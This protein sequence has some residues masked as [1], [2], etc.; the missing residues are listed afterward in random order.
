MRLTQLALKLSQKRLDLK[1]DPEIDG[2][3]IAMDIQG[4]AENI[5]KVLNLFP[6]RKLT[7]P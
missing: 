6:Q 1:N 3:L 7:S 5:T 4:T 2:K